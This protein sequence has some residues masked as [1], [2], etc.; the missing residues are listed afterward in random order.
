V[1]AVDRPQPTNARE[2]NEMNHTTHASTLYVRAGLVV[3]V[4]LFAL[5]SAF[6]T[7]ARAEFGIAPGTF[8]IDNLRSDGI[9]EETQAAGHPASSVSA[10]DLNLVEDRP[11][12]YLRDVEVTLPPG[13]VG[14]PL[15]AP[16]CSRSD[17]DELIGSFGGP[18]DA[19]CPPG[20]Q[21]GVGYIDFA[22]DFAFGQPPTV[23]QMTVPIYNVQPRPGTVADLGMSVATVPVHLEV[24]VSK[25]GDHELKVIGKKISQGMPVTAQKL[26]LWGNPSD[27]AH[28]TERACGRGFLFLPAPACPVGSPP[29]PFLTNPTSC[30]GPL[31]S[32]VRLDSWSEPGDWKEFSYATASGL[33]GCESVPFEPDLKARPTTRRANS[34]TGLDVTV[35]LPQDENVGGLATAHLKDAVVTLPEGMAISPS[36]ADGL[37]DC[38]PDQIGLVSTSPVRFDGEPARCPDSSKIGSALIEAP[39]IDHPLEGAIYLGRQDNPGRDGV[40]NPFDSLLSLYVVIDDAESGIQLKLPAEVS[41]DERTGRIATRFMRNPQLPFSEFELRFSDGPGAALVSPPTCGSYA[42]S[43]AFDS[44]SGRRVELSDSFVID[45]GPGGG[46]C[47]A[48]SFAPTLSAGLVS[49]VAASSSPFLLS[50]A[51]GD[52]DQAISSLE[53]DLPTGL[54]AKLAGVPYCADASLAAISSSPSSGFRELGGSAC[55]AASQVGV[56]TVGAGAGLSPFYV[57]TGKAYLAGPYKGAPLSLAVVVPAVAGPF[58][59]GSVVVRNRIVVD[60][61]DAQVHLVSDPLP[62][63]LSGIPLQLRDIR[64]SADRPGFMQA[65]TNCA[66]KSVG[67]VVRGAGGATA[68]LSNRFQVGECASL[69]FKPSL[70]LSVSGPTHRS[71]HPRLK[72]VLT[73]PRGGANI[74][75]AQVTLPKTEILAQEHIRTICTR[76]QY[77]AGKGGGAACPPASVY[78]KAKAWSPLLDKPLQGPV[79]LRSSSNKLPD[80]VASLDGQIHVDLVGRIDAVNARIRNTF[81]GVPDAPVSKFVLE[82]QGGKKGLLVNNTELCKTVPRATV[83]FD[84]QNGKIADS[85]P[86]MRAD[87]GKKA[88][89]RSGAK[90]R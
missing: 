69:A 3:A 64:V 31:T 17:F 16:R 78:G 67:A 48:G 71:A 52:G 75:R 10:F 72:A 85:S 19:A 15:A 76:V 5:A 30:S 13:F 7:P 79:F 59:L 27:P 54:S 80:L 65:P 24:V 22:V 45:R 26:V 61:D 18:D 12:E 81:E 60:P 46:E 57:K 14:N 23:G 28:D 88:K 70:K 29:A 53:V 44:W 4:L 21:I 47:A 37:G 56:A 87:C 1:I 2:L 34:P 73:M 86:V 90:K 62:Q 36:A 51:R 20:S 39:A 66:P 33:T 63:I 55:P 83:A 89:K 35:S 40:E 84:G 77:N 82:M 9:A 8:A 41:L 38:G 6:A 43:A 32:H 42:T 49:P 68:R 25:S 74:A 11:D 50:L 58:D